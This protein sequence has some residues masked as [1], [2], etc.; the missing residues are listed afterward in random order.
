MVLLLL[1]TVLLTLLE[2]SIAQNLLAI[3]TYGHEYKME[4]DD[5]PK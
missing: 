5:T 3:D 4:Y 1:F 2:P